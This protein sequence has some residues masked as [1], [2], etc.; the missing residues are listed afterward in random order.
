[1]D[2]LQEAIEFLEDDIRKKQNQ[3]K[4]L[5]TLDFNEPVTEER[6]HEICETYLRTSDLMSHIVK[7]TFP[8]AEDIQIGANYA[9]FTL[10]GIQC[11]LPNS[12]CRGIEVDTKWYEKDKFSYEFEH[13]F[14]DH[15]F[16][17]REYLQ[18]SKPTWRDKFD[19]YD[20]YGKWRYVS[21]IK[22]LY[23]Y[24]SHYKEI[25]EIT[26]QQTLEKQIQEWKDKYEKA[27]SENKK[28]RDRLHNQAVLMK[29]KLL[30]EL[31]KFTNNIREY[32]NA[33][34]SFACKYTIHEILEIEGLD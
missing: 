30:P 33:G 1:M 3:L 27:L 19:Y 24:F 7:A 16:R 13:Y 2:D 10:Y 6:W 9:Y 25:N 32:H 34:Y 11:S 8:E 4:L 12:L 29:E 31:S 22:R 23:V 15:A 14:Y 20:L 5:K 28:E 17:L 26:C 21:K 18:I